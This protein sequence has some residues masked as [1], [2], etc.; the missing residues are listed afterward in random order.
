M[1]PKKKY[2]KI[3]VK[4]KISC[5]SINYFQYFIVKAEKL[6]VQVSNSHHTYRPTMKKFQ[7]KKTCLHNVSL[8]PLVEAQPYAMCAATKLL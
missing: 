5:L 1:T 4:A 6:C 7:H 8:P 2:F 3:N